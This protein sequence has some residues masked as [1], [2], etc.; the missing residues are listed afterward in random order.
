MFERI[1]ILL[2]LFS[3][4]S[5][6]AEA[7]YAEGL[8]FVSIEDYI[9]KRKVIGGVYTNYFP[10]LKKNSV[11]KIILK[12]EDNKTI[13][14]T[15]I[16]KNGYP[17]AFKIYSASDKKL[18]KESHAQY[19]SLNNLIS[20]TQN[21]LLSNQKIL[22]IFGYYENSGP[23]IKFETIVNGKIRDKG[24]MLYEMLSFTSPMTSIESTIWNYD[25]TN[26]LVNLIYGHGIEEVY[27]DDIGEQT[28]YDD[29]ILTMRVSGDTNVL[30]KIYGDGNIMNKSGYVFTIQSK[31]GYEV[32]HI[33]FREDKL[34]RHTIY[35]NKFKVQLDKAY[36]Y[37]S[38]TKLIDYIFVVDNNQKQ[39]I[40]KF[41]YEYY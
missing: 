1:I 6:E 34:L 26:L 33:D 4:I 3:L 41:K 14:E 39:Y 19:D 23:I 27:R 16:N 17:I 8:E 5:I 9:A 10:L 40:N 11:K 21:D 20:I 24:E 31:N 12:D 7:Q 29:N 36:F 30:Y 13:S 37:N 2:V 15:E 25:S 22:A 18:N 38:E 28:K 35:D 32:Y